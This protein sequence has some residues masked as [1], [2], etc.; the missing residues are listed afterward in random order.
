MQAVEY[1]YELSYTLFQVTEK[2]L[3]P[4]SLTGT[5]GLTQG[6]P[7]QVSSTHRML[8][9]E[10][11]HG[12]GKLTMVFSL[13]LLFMLWVVSGQFVFHLTMSSRFL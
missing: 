8:L 7:G 12:R 2:V 5:F 13:I 10:D 9:A 1:N 3:G 6:F 11:K 4:D